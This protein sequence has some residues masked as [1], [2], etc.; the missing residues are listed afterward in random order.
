MIRAG[1]SKADLAR[2][3]GV[4]A[5][6][7]AT[8]LRGGR[9]EKGVWVHPNPRDDFLA[10]LAAA[11]GIDAAELFDRAGGT[12]EERNGRKEVGGA[13]AGRPTFQ[14]LTERVERQQRQIDELL[15]WMR[16]ARE[17]DSGRARGRDGGNRNG[18]RGRR[19]EG[20]RAS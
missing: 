10:K 17:R 13:L 4:S 1:R 12:F 8:L 11:L 15:A 18:P 3:A 16:Q 14:E 2:A 19:D 5:N 9:H 7:V 20:G 6:A